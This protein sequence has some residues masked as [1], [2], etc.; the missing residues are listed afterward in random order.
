MGRCVQVVPPSCETATCSGAGAALPFSWPLNCAQQTYTVPKK[1][2]DDALSAQTCSLSENVVLGCLEMTTGGLHV[3][4]MLS[5]AE[6]TS[7][8]R[9]TAIAAKPLNADSERVSPKF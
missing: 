1:R 3:A 7:S 5:S 9:E 2:L 8:V 4:L 6:A